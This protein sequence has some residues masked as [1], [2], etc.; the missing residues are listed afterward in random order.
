[1]IMMRYD[2]G[3]YGGQALAKYIYTQIQNFIIC[4]ENI[5]LHAQARLYIHRP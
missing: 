3:G 1:M 4:K 5:V 2:R